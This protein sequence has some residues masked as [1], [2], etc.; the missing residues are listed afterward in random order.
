[1]EHATKCSRFSLDEA[2]RAAG[3]EP[4]ERDGENRAGQTPARAHPVRRGRRRRPGSRTPARRAD[5]IRV[6]GVQRRFQRHHAGVRFLDRSA[7]RRQLAPSVTAA[8]K[9]SP[10]SRTPRSPGTLA[11]ATRSGMRLRAR[12]A[13]TSRGTRDSAAETRRRS[14]RPAANP[15]FP[16]VALRPRRNVDRTPTPS[17][18]SGVCR[19]GGMASSNPAV[20]ARSGRPFARRTRPRL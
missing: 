6:V 7:E 16:R 15:G 12:R 14:G 4:R 8:R 2:A 5:Q 20:P 11:A 18:S 19:R 10:R 13:E 3:P 1:M 9:R 17:A